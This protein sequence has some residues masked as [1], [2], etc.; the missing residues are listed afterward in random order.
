MSVSNL[1]FYFIDALI[2]RIFLVDDR[3]ADED[4]I[5][6][7]RIIGGGFRRCLFVFFLR[8]ARFRRSDVSLVAIAIMILSHFF[9]SE[10]PGKIAGAVI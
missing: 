2:Q 8:A 9:I 5:F 10:R 6:F 4:L 7:S 1:A 3:L